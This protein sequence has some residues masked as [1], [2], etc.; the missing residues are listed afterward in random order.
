MQK[1][2]KSNDGKEML[3]L[4]SEMMDEIEELGLDSLTILRLVIG[5]FKYLFKNKQKSSKERL[6][7]SPVRENVERRVVSKKRNWKMIGKIMNK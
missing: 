7:L 1:L 4:T 6:S 2:L 5:E 3:T